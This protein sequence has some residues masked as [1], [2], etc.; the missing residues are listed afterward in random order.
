M[1]TIIII[2]FLTSVVHTVILT[3]KEKKERQKQDKELMDWIIELENRVYYLEGK[4]N[5]K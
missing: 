5:N 2:L 4:N 3:V 1:W